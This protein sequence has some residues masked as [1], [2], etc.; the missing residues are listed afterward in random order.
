MQQTQ[1]ARFVCKTARGW[2]DIRQNTVFRQ[3]EFIYENVRALVN[4]NNN[5]NKI[6]NM[7]QI[8]SD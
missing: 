2:I 7:F 3:S 8:N 5:T 4:K 6:K 1:H